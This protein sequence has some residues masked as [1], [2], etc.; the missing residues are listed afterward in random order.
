MGHSRDALSPNLTF[1][2]LYVEPLIHE[3]EAKN[4]EAVMHP[5]DAPRGLFDVDPTQT[6][7]LLLDVKAEP[8]K[9][10]PLLAQSLEPLRGRGWLTSV[11]GEKINTGPVTVV[12]TGKLP[13]YI[14]ERGA[15]GMNNPCDIFLDAPLS[16]LG[17]SPFHTNNSYWASDS[18]AKKIGHVWLGRLHPGQIHRV[19]QHVKEAHSR[20]LKV[21]YWGLPVWP[22][23]LRDNVWK[24]LVQEG[25]DIVNVDD[26]TG[27]AEAWS[28]L[29]A[30]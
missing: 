17:D 10:W 15:D 18:F 22:L 25:V 27:V 30:A 16:T 9:T 28:E 14:L 2:G 1:K 8:A 26:L 23:P 12:V 6:L 7:V 19:R 20:G 4:R 5:A 21:R 24:T 3:L 13:A 29:R 11:R